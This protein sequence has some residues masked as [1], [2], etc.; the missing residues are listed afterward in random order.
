FETTDGDASAI[1]REH[2]RKPRD[3][4]IN[5][6]SDD[7]A[8]NT[9]NSGRDFSDDVEGL[10]R[11]IEKLRS[12][13]AASAKRGKQLSWDT[14]LLVKK[15]LGLGGTNIVSCS[16]P[17]WKQLMEQIEIGRQGIRINDVKTVEQIEFIAAFAATH[18]LTMTYGRRSFY[19][20]PRQSPSA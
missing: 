3:E 17:N 14:E 12:L 4:T 7:M 2:M 18:Q 11:E 9:E 15:T 5:A 6:F 1:S 10:R 16:D 8:D 13:L 20:E 19:L